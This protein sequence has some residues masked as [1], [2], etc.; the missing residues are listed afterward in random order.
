MFNVREGKPI[1]L[2]DFSEPE[3]DLAIVQPLGRMYLTHH[4]EPENIFWV[5]EFSASSLSKDLETKRR[6]YA[7]AG[8]AE[9][10]VMNLVAM[11]LQV[12]RNP[13]AGDYQTAEILTTGE[14]HP[15]AFPD[16]TVSVEKLLGD[17][18]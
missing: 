13:Q 14:L 7:G 4:P 2:P 12:F 9:Y 8:I 6:I 11:H 5:I 15:L 16:I 10:W 3:P 1:T 17:D 18:K